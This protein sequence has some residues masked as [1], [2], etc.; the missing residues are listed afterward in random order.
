MKVVPVFLLFLLFVLS[1]CLG[2]FQRG[3]AYFRNQEYEK[4]IAEFDRVL[5]VSISDVKSLHLRARSFEELEEYEKA[6]EDY[7]KILKLQPTYSQALAGLGKIAWKENNMPDA[8]KFLLKAAMHDPND[9]DILM[10]LGRTMIKNQ[11]FKSAEEFLQLASDQHPENPQPYFYIGI[12]RGYQGDG[13]GVVTALN[14]YLS[15]EN[16]NLAAH[17]NRGFALM[18]LGFSDWAIEDFNEVLKRKPDHYDAL[19]RR[20]ICLLEDNPSQGMRDIQKAAQH[21]NP[22][23]KSILNQFG[24]KS[25]RGMN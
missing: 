22:L 11:R 21:G 6:K 17:Y 23:A 16:D 10:L 13:L 18:K 8:E 5:F 1:G 15:L 2:Q 20:G 9:Y 25:G 3:E 4:A 19:A 14:A 7:R 12:A 24:K